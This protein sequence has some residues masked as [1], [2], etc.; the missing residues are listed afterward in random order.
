MNFLLIKGPLYGNLAFEAREQI[1]EKIRIKME[2]HGL[3][4]VEYDWVWDEDDRCLLVVGKYENMDDAGYLIKALENMG[5]KTCVRTQLP[6]DERA[7]P[8]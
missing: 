3:R 6:G 7:R 8:Q 1:R 2:D 4:Y 5:F